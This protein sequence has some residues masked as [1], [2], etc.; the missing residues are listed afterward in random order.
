[1]AA[2]VTVHVNVL[3][4]L[5]AAAML[6]CVAFTAGLLCGALDRRNHDE[7]DRFLENLT[8]GKRAA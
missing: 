5:L 8:T 6:F 2:I 3:V 7:L 4:L 1:M